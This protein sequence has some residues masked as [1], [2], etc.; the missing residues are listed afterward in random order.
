[1]GY[2]AE[3]DVFILW[4][5]GLYTNFA[6]SRNV[7]VKAETII[8]ASAGKLATQERQL[9]APGSEVTRE[10]VLAVKPRLLGDAIVK[11][12]ELTRERMLKE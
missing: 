6:W 10:T 9:R 1:M 5:A 7:Q 4:D 3:E 12:M 8:A 11:R 2:A